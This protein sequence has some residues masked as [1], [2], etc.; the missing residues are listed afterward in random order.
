VRLAAG[1]VLVLAAVLA[2][3]AAAANAPIQR[4]AA[5]DMALARRALIGKAD[6]GKG[7]ESV[8]AVTGRSTL[9]CKS[10]NPSMA[11]IVETGTASA[12]FRGTAQVIGQVVWVYRTAAQAATL[13]RR[14]AG[15]G[16][17]CCLVEA[18][19]SAGGLQVTKLKSG[20]LATPKLAGRTAAFRVIA[21]AKVQGKPIDLTYDNFLL[22]QGRTVTQITFGSA[23]P[24]PS[25]VEVALARVVAKRLGT[26]GAA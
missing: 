7:W 17:L 10:S 20:A 3:P 25:A 18:A 8:R 9:T 6:V 15:K 2:G 16:F 26:T 23:R 1:L 14:A 22:A 19:R 24:I 5:K 13:W 4:H 11:G 21:T 12:G